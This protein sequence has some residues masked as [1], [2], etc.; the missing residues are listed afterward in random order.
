MLATVRRW[1]AKEPCRELSEALGEAS[2]PSFQP[3]VLQVLKLLRDPN[4]GFAKIGEAVSMDPGLTVR[5]LRIVN[6][7]AYGLRRRVDNVP[8]AAAILSRSGLEQLVLGVAVKR[9]VP[10]KTADRDFW[11]TASRRAAT[12]RALAER[13][14]PSR[15]SL[16]FC[17]GLLQDLAVPLLAGARDDYADVRRSAADSGQLA[18]LEQQHFGWSHADVAGW[19]CEAWGFPD[20]LRRAI[21]GHHGAEDAPLAVQV[22]ALVESSTSDD[23]DAFIDAAHDRFAVRRD[24]VRQALAEG[25]ELGDLLAAALSTS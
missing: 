23:P 11:R 7:P 9:T 25:Q 19:L 8:H 10:T 21:A 1:F 20:S 14:D 5:V 22:V 18:D 15:A 13:V 12:A 24:V 4:T 2:I 3:A 6:S 17:G 16:C